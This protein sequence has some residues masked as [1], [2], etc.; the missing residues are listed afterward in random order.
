[1][2]VSSLILVSC[3]GT[4]NPFITEPAQ[5]NRM[6]HIDQSLQDLP[7]PK[8]KI[9]TA[10][11]DF[12]DKTGQYKPTQGISYST[13]VTQGASAIL[14]KALSESGWFS[15]IER[16]GL[17]DLLNERRIIQSTRA[18]NND[19]TKLHPLL[20]AGV[21]IEGGIIGYSSNVIT[22]GGGIRYLGMGISG[23]FRKDQVTV[24]LR[25]VSTQTG[26][27][28]KSVRTTKS[29]L[30]QKISAGV[31]RY[32][33]ANKLLEAE[34]GVTFNE[35]SIMAVTEAINAAVKKLI[36]AGVKDGLWRP[37]HKEVFQKYAKKYH[38]AM[39][40]QAQK[41]R[42]IYGL[43]HR[44]EQRKGYTFSLNYT[45]GSY[46]GGYGGEIVYPGVM[47]GIE[48]SLSPVFSLK[49]NLQR[50]RIGSQELFSKPVNNADLMLNAY[51]MPDF[52]FTP[53]IAGGFG[54]VF[55]FQ[56]RPDFTSKPDVF[57]P[58]LAGEVGIDYRITKK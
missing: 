57:F 30:S 21:L 9:V 52:T 23:Q 45:Y 3:A 5:I 46:I 22:G 12:R 29:I 24:Y 32:V 40:R 31:F 26:R 4:M 41:M 15:P 38:L 27:I 25:V 47:L 7:K 6:G 14:I 18:K 53:Y 50:S 16:T 43:V 55:S 51:L 13:A 54:A 11:Y 19:N 35:P 34:A 56:Q 58:A 28:L 2:A 17:S 10:V 44:P 20:F 33:D 8:R 48:R 37:K 49:L 36:I 42:D 1:M 39:K